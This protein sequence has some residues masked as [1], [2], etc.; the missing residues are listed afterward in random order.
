[1]TYT[2]LVASIQN[3]SENSFDYS[4]TPSILNRFVEQAEQTIYNAVQLPSLRRN[5][6]GLTTASN[7]YLSCP[8]DFLSSFSL[9]AIDSSGSYTYLLN[10]DVNFIRQA[11]PNPTDTGLPY[12]YALFGPQSTNEAELSFILGPTPDAA[13]TMELHYYFYP[14]SIVT[15][16]VTWLGDNFDIALLNYCLVE[17]ITY[18]K[19]EQDMVAL[20]KGRAEN[21]LVLLK[22]LGDAKEKG[23]SYRDGS[24]K[25][26]VI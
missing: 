9:A 8:T 11:Y 19:G 22:Q 21:A 16:G 14:Q 12:Y 17:A 20:Y 18:M 15:A 7:K 23:D 2:E 6:T 5:V 25:Y 13:Y 26:K 1:M 24:P 4:T 3:Y 10:K